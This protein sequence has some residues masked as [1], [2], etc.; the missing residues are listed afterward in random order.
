MLGYTEVPDA[1]LAQLRSDLQTVT[2]ERD[3]ATRNKNIAVERLAKA[4]DGWQ[5]ALDEQEA[6]QK[7]FKAQE[8]LAR[9]AEH[10][11]AEVESER[12]A[13]LAHMADLDRV[14]RV[15]RALYGAG[16]WTRVGQGFTA[17][18]DTSYWEAM[19]QALAAL[20]KV[21]S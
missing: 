15:A 17:E 21:E 20:P 2:Q 10:E 5:Q 9:Q 19:K 7:R 16:Y 8:E 11:C 1:E 12:D 4:E 13:G 14:A 3:E 6:W 18:G